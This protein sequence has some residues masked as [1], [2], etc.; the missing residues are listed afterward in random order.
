MNDWTP[1]PK[2]AIALSV[3]PETAFEILFGG[4]RG[5]GKTDAGI[6]WLHGDKIGEFQDG[7]PKYY[8]H[9]PRY[10]A[11]VLR[12]NYDDLVDWIDRATNLY[13]Y[14]GVEVV[15]KPAE[16]RWPS[17]AKFRLGHLSDRS[18]YE[19]YLGHEYH[20]ALVE[21]LTLIPAENHYIKIL[22]SVRTS[23]PELKPQVFNT[24]NPGNVGHGWVRERFVTPAPYGTPFVGK[25][26]LKKIYIPG[27]IEDN[28][29]LMQ[30]KNYLVYLESLKETDPD[31]YRAWRFGDWDVFAG[32]FFKTFRKNLHVCPGFVPKVSLPKVAGADWGFDPGEFVFLAISV[33]QVDWEGV[34]FNRA[35]VFKEIAGTEKTPT[36]W[37][38]II[39]GQLELKEFSWIRGDPAMNI[40]KADGSIS[41]MDQFKNEGVTILPANNDRINGWIAVRKWLSLAPDGLPYLMISENCINLIKTIPE[42]IH[43]ETNKEDLDTLARDH[44]VDALRYVLIHLKWIDARTGAV[45]RPNSRPM[46]PKFVGMVDLSKF[47]VKKR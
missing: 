8:I 13:R 21:E 32:Q 29:V 23:I 3:S 41:I 10:R 28:P 39:K 11:L 20:R 35:W 12:K 27:T 1:F 7:R 4:A 31:L 43:D 34:R 44:Y 46:P 17:G 37:A 6:Q 33:E 47:E 18:S 2:Q 15:G 36:A 5:P 26:G 9:H 22:G 30:D 14:A 24:T 25:D 42:M 16:V 40:K 19:K 45:L 38:E